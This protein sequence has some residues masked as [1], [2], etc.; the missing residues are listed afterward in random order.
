MIWLLIVFVAVGWVIWSSVLPVRGLAYVDSK[1]AD[2]VELNVS[3]LTTSYQM[4]DVRDSVDYQ[5]CHVP[6]S[7]NISIG[8]LPYLSNKELSADKPVLIL[9]DNHRQ[10][11]KAARILKKSGFAHLYAL[12][13]SK[14][15][16]LS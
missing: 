7:V 6:D 12:R 10:S 3:K 8:R 4:L 13:D 14:V 9:A 2:Q 1:Q 16:C 15:P 11:K 5:K